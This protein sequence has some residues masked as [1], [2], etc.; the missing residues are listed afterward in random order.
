[1][2]EIARHVPGP[3]VANMLEQG[4]TL[5]GELK[6]LELSITALTPLRLFA[7]GIFKGVTEMHNTARILAVRQSAGVAQ[8]MNR[9]LYRTAVKCLFVGPHAQP[10]Q[11]DHRGFFARVGQA[12]DKI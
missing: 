11:R 10:E 4:V 2:K 9:L 12:E 3:L 5:N 7:V 6:I 1:M 8:F